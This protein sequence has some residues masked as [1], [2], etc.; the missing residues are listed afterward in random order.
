M[1]KK[2]EEPSVAIVD[3]QSVKTIQTVFVDGGYSGTLVDWGLQMFGWLISVVKRTEAH[4]FKILPKRWIV[5][6]TF[7]WMN[8][9]RRLSKDYEKNPLYSEA[10]IYVAMVNIMTRRLAVKNKSIN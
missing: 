7:G 5:E 8:W 9:R 2:N 10:M 1:R 3:S 6:R 4:T